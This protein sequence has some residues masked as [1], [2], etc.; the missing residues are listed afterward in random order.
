MGQITVSA[1]RWESGSTYKLRAA[2]TS[3]FSLTERHYPANFRVPEHRHFHTYIVVTL[4]GSFTSTYTSRTE[5]YRPWTISFHAA[6]T[7]HTT[8]YSAAGA[9]ALYIEIPGDEL[10]KLN[11]IPSSHLRTFVVRSGSVLERARRMYAEFRNPDPLS[12]MVMDGLIL[13]LL[14]L[15]HKQLS[16]LPSNVPVWL[17]RADDLIRSQFRERL[18]LPAIATAVG[19]HP[20]HLARE[21]RRYFGC[22]IGEQI[23]RLRIEFC[24]DQLAQTD[25]SLAV[26][27]MDSGFSDPSHFSE[28]FRHCVGIAP[29]E[30]RQTARVG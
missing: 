5:E 28:S 23:R 12:P 8:R 1:P 25:R 18:P 30:Y 6:D 4:D 26:I 10:K 16:L 15:A 2:A 22:T 11:Q 20:V 17:G 14:G 13:E 24:C 3:R 29:S 27:A 21:Y 19:V 9:K 7:S